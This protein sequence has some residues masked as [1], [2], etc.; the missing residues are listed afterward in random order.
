MYMHLI[1]AQSYDVPVHFGDGLLALSAGAALAFLAV[2][3]FDQL[4]AGLH[5]LTRLVKLRHHH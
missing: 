2:V 1:D 3:Y 4:L 5:Q